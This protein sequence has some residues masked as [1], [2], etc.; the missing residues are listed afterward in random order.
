MQKLV[1][2]LVV[3]QHIV[4]PVV[5]IWRY[6]RQSAARTTTRLLFVVHDVCQRTAVV[7]LTMKQAALASSTVQGG[8]KRRSAIPPQ[9]FQFRKKSTAF[10]AAGK[11]GFSYL[12]TCSFPASIE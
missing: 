10:T 6:W 9:S 2:L 3:A 1:C 4:S 12:R 7:S 11:N 8:G 5:P